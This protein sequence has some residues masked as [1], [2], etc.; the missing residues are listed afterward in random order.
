[1]CPSNDRTAAP[2]ATACT[3]RKRSAPP[4]ASRSPRRENS[5]DITVSE[6]GWASGRTSPPSATFQSLISPERLGRPLPDANRLPSGANA[7]DVTMSIGGP[8]TSSSAA[9]GVPSPP[10][11]RSSDQG[12]P[13]SQIAAADVPPAT[14]IR[15]PPTNVAMPPGPAGRAAS[16]VDR[17][18]PSTAPSTSILPSASRQASQAPSPEND[19]DTNG[20]AD[21]ADSA[22]VSLR[23]CSSAAS[24][25]SAV[26]SSVARSGTS[27]L[28]RFSCSAANSTARV[29][30]ATESSACFF[31]SS[32][33]VW[34]AVA[35]VAFFVASAACT[36]ACSTCCIARVT[37]C[38]LRP[39]A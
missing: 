8:A 26:E 11:V 30:V 19:A 25:D 4:E 37:V 23:A 33:V 32:A 35:A 14:S 36:F 9:G 17:A 29:A 15:V 18:W 12:S 21:T 28:V 13:A 7:S 22:S 39:F 38:S 31:A 5:S 6:C 34:A 10:I 2:S 27:A 20:L 16:Q 1:M 24:W 3:F